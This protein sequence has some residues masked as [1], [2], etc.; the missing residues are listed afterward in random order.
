MKIDWSG[1]YG[2]SNVKEILSQLIKSSKVPHAFLFHG[3]EGVGKFS[4][5]IRFAQIINSRLSAN[6]QI[7][8][9]ISSL[10][11]PYIKYIIPLPRGKYE[12]DESGP[13]ESLSSEDIKELKEELS[14]KIENPYYNFKLSRANNIKI[15]SIREIARFLSLSYEDVKYRVILISDAQLMNDES[16][17]ALLKNLEEPP[18]GVI[19]ILMTPY[20]DTLRETIR[21]RCWLIN[22]QPLDDDDIKN[23]LVN[24]FK[25]DRKTA[26]DVAHFSSGSV[27]KA[28][29]LIENDFEDLKEKTISIMRYSF[30]GKFHSALNEIGPYLSE[31]DSGSMKLLIRLIIT[32][33]NDIQKYRYNN[34][35]FYFKSHLETIEKF[36]TKFP[37]AN[38][39]EIIVK[40]DNI[41]T[42][43][44][45]NVNLNTLALNLIYELA[46]LTNR[47]HK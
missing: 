26:E 5:S 34:K 28:L 32:W 35:Q 6:P 44:K 4:L 30:G 41:S 21:S 42:I 39:N 19:F 12:T 36:S 33:L 31:K 47:L 17:N 14:K 7:I 27:T 43:M 40:L 37:D 25:I 24:N 2:Q 38:L 3:P 16:Q 18:A 20:P 10:S 45:N 46:S 8:N 15:N 29:D 13:V 22:F 1:I 11:E 9:L 23:I